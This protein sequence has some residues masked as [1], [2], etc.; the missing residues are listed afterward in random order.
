MNREISIVN[1]T[2]HNASK[3]MRFYLNPSKVESAKSLSV[4]YYKNYSKMFCCFK[5][6][7]NLLIQGTKNCEFIMLFNFK[8][9]VL[10]CNCCSSSIASC[11]IQCT[12]NRCLIFIYGF[13]SNRVLFALKSRHFYTVCFY[14]RIVCPTFLS[15]E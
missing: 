6:N 4:I 2:L 8:Y 12:Q 7:S 11:R 14:H 15:I 9:C 5:K 1:S 13:K 10:L 3:N